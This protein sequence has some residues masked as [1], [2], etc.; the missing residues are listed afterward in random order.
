VTQFKGKRVCQTPDVSQT[1]SK[2]ESLIPAMLESSNQ[3]EREDPREEIK[4][5][6]YQRLFNLA[7]HKLQ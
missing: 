1:R 6:D 7:A 4:S 3:R 5:P 2:T